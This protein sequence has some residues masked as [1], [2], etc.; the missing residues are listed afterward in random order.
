MKIPTY[1]LGF[2]LIDKN[3]KTNFWLIKGFF[4]EI[5]FLSYSC[6]KKI[7]IMRG[8]SQTTLTRFWL[9]D[10][11][12]PYVDY[13][14]CLL[15]VFILCHILKFIHE[16]PRTLKRFFPHSGQF[17]MKLPKVHKVMIIFS[18]LLRTHNLR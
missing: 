2:F 16:I 14:P 11:L 5:Y 3:K 10:H 17:S 15:N 6:K 12:P 1:F 13:L 7:K 4:Q 9:F 18:V 8:S